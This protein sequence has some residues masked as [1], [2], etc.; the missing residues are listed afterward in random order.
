[1]ARKDVCDP[2]LLHQLLTQESLVSSTDEASAIIES[3]IQENDFDFGADISDTSEL[4]SDDR[5]CRYVLAEYFGLNDH[6]VT[7]LSN[8]YLVS[9]SKQ[10]VTNQDY[11]EFDDNN[12]VSDLDEKCNAILADAGDD[13]D[14]REEII[15]PGECE[16][17]ERDVAKLTRHHLIPKSTWKRIESM[18]LTR[19]NKAVALSSLQVPTKI[20]DNAGANNS[21]ELDHLVPI[22]LEISVSVP[23]CNTNHGRQAAA[24]RRIVRDLLNR[25]TIDICRHCHDHIHRSYDNKALSLQFNTLTKLLNDPTIAKYAKWASRQHRFKIR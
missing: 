2:K 21:Y 3:I 22:L 7:K 16:L 24:G 11:D 9:K 23:S 6:D 13:D 15:G 25:Q 8:I 12:D 19:W 1:M 20:N 4:E 14:D 17:C 5:F 18:I 10:N